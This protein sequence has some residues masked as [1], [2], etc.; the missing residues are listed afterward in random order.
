[1]IVN[2]GVD[3]ETKNSDFLLRN[4]RSIKKLRQRIETEEKQEPLYEKL[5]RI[6]EGKP[7]IK[8]MNFPDPS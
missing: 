3:M 1:M 5:E 7:R 8:R 4:A 2:A 6:H